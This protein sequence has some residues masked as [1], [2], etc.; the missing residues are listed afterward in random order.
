M[1]IPVLFTQKNSNYDLD[2]KFDI[3][4]IN[5]NALTCISRSAAIYH[6]PC[7]SWGR[8]RGLANRIPVEHWYAV[9]SVIRCRRFGGVIEHPAGSTLWKLMKLPL[10]G[11]KPDNFGGWS[12]SI[13]QSWFGFKAAK[14]TWLYIVGISPSEL[15]DYPISFNAITH[16]VSTS[17]KMAGKKELSKNSKS[18]TPAELCKFLYNICES[19]ELKKEYQ[20]GKSN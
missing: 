15:P 19:I 10:P 12:M 9:W 2:H 17:K 3:Y 6:P 8:L 5:R 16:C 7:R 1:K 11:S 18:K 14:N 13:N 4:D 20:N